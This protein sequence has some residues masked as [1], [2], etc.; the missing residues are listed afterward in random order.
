MAATVRV[1]R[2]LARSDGLIGYSSTHNSSTRRSGRCRCGRPPTISSASWS[3]MS[4]APPWSASDLIWNDHASK[5]PPYGAHS[6]RQHGPTHAESSGEHACVL[7]LDRF[8]VE[9]RGSVEHRA[10]RVDLQGCTTM[11][12]TCCFVT[13]ARCASCKSSSPNVAANRGW[14]SPRSMSLTRRAIVPGGA[15]VAPAR[16]RSR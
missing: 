14:S 13:N 10:P 8:E 11:L 16:V 1:A 4:T 2:Q 12:P 5:R 7:V 9:T 15:I 6:C 3:P